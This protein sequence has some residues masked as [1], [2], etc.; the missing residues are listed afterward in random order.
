M[1]GKCRVVLFN[2]AVKHSIP[3]RSKINVILLPVEGDPDA[4]PHFWGLTAKTGGLLL[5]PAVGWP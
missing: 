4:G 3:A 5:V 1:S 2:T